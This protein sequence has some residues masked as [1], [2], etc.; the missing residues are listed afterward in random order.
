MKKFNE[1][2]N[3]YVDT[4]VS[5]DVQAMLNNHFM[6]REVCDDD[7]FVFFWS[8][9]IN[10][11]Y[12]KFIKLQLTEL[13]TDF[14][15][16]F[17]TSVNTILT[18]TSNNT[19]TKS[20]SDKNSNT[21]NS[22]VTNTIISDST[23]KQLDLNTPQSIQYSNTQKASNDLDWTYVS[24]QSESSSRGSD[25]STT[26]DG[27]SSNTTT[28]N[29]SVSSISSSNNDSTTSSSGYNS[30]QTT[31]YREAYNFISN[32]DSFTWFVSKLEICFLGIYEKNE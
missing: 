8:R 12:D 14:D 10:R 32:S 27:S 31:R 1:F 21:N 23:N 11:Y 15:T 19:D 20:G 2:S 26:S 24:R 5:T 7:N 30:S 25:T 4:S 6:Y 16:D 3:I 29:S 13:V 17:K 22:S 18:S 28:Y 9:N